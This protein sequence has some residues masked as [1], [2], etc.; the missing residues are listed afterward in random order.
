MNPIAFSTQHMSLCAVSYRIYH[1]YGHCKSS[2][3]GSGLRV[4]DDSAQA[5][6]EGGRARGWTARLRASTTCR[7]GNAEAHGVNVGI[8]RCIG[9]VSDLSVL[10]VNVPTQN[11][12]RQCHYVA[13]VG[14]PGLKTHLRRNTLSHAQSTLR[15]VCAASSSTLMECEA[16]TALGASNAAP[17][18]L[19]C[20]LEL[21]PPLSVAGRGAG[22]R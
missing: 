20:R 18:Q 15:G 13:L 8:G 10:A 4:V 22:L 16:A 6:D 3:R 1:G 9:R 11:G 14:M 2:S 21:R 5:E 19:P 17:H 7:S 12:C